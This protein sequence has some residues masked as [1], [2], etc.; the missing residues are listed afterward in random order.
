MVRSS[1]GRSSDAGPLLGLGVG[2]LSVNTCSTSDNSFFCNYSRIFQMIMW[3][4]TLIFIVWIVFA[5]LSPLVF[6]AFSKR[7]RGSKGWL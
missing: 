4:I 5:L 2:A 6:A 3:T 1:G 7:G